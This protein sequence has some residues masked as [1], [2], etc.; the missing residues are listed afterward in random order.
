M[1]KISLIIVSL[2]VTSFVMAQQKKVTEVATISFPSGTQKL[3]GEQMRTNQ[4]ASKSPILQASSKMN[5]Y[6]HY[7]INSFFLEMY[8]ETV[9]KEKYT[10][11]AAMKNIELIN[12]DSKGTSRFVSGI[13]KVNNYSM[14]IAQA[15]SK[16]W[17][18]YAFYILNE[19]STKIINGILHYESTPQNK[20]E[21][22]KLLQQLL[23][24]I[25]FKE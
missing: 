15:D 22:L 18:Y 7:S 17:G 6:E 2:L 24:S 11:E 13:K 14:F 8:T 25:K 12:Q 19:D 21:G 23:N 5:K 4:A 16:D 1:K 9:S 20:T 3:S 10:L